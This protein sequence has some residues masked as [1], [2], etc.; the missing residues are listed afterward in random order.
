MTLTI[1]VI[2]LFLIAAAG[3]ICQIVNFEK[4][5][6]P[7]KDA[8]YISVFRRLHWTYLVLFLA[9]AADKIVALIQKL[10]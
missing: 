6:K 8:D 5:V 9:F 3:E 4:K 7:E 2:C 1:I 10:Q